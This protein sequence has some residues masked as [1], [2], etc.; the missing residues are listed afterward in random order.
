MKKG[1]FNNSPFFSRSHLF[2]A[3][4]KSVFEKD[5]IHCSGFYVALICI[6]TYILPLA[7]AS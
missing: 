2:I 3:S 4:I 1:E 7:T 5:M 6:T